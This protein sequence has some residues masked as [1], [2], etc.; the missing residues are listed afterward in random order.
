M[1]QYSLQDVE[2]QLSTDTSGNFR[3]YLLDVLRQYKE[4]FE[5]SKNK[6]LPVEEY[7]LIEYLYRAIDAAIDIIESKRPENARDVAFN[8][9]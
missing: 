3:R 4:E 1:P 5:V 6:M 2:A 9:F 7:E 8:N